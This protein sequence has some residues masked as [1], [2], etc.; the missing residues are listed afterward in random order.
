[1]FAWDWSR[2]DWRHQEGRRGDMAR[3]DTREVREDPGTP[4]TIGEREESEAA[5]PGRPGGPPTIRLLWSLSCRLRPL[6]G[7]EHGS[8]MVGLWSDVSSLTQGEWSRDH[9]SSIMP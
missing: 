8:V 4:Q 6:A 5:Q 1:M 2:R 3:G 7:S 9:A